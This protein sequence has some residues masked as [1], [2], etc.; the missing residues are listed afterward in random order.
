VTAAGIQADAVG[1]CGRR[2]QRR[3]RRR[4]RSALWRP[5]GTR[6]ISDGR[7]SLVLRRDAGGDGDLLSPIGRGPLR[8]R[9]AIPAASGTVAN[10][11]RRGPP[12]LRNCDRRGAPFQR[13]DRE[14]CPFEPA[15]RVLRR[16]CRVGVLRCR[17]RRP[18][19]PHV[20]SSA[21]RRRDQ[22]RARPRIG[23]RLVSIGASALVVVLFALAYES[24]ARTEVTN[25]GISGRPWI[26]QAASVAWL[27]NPPSALGERVWTACSC[28]ALDLEALWS[29]RPISRESDALLWCPT[30]KR[31]FSGCPTVIIAPGPVASDSSL[32][33]GRPPPRPL[34]SEAR[35]MDLDLSSLWRISRLPH[36]TCRL[37]SHSVTVR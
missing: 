35:P 32:R 37:G 5:G 6:R 22:S 3:G 9:S 7:R 25:P 15:A 1:P 14:F 30:A 20:G 36:W 17:S 18:D 19:R 8:R 11:F 12:D 16:D 4:G 21:G 27:P 29:T 34:P 2:S 24:Y 13:L 23:W 26:V 33:F 28:L 31:S 10:S